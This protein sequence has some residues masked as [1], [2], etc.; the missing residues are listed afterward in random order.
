MMSWCSVKK[1]D[2]Y[3]PDLFARHAFRSYDTGRFG[4]FATSHQSHPSHMHELDTIGGQARRKERCLQGI[5]PQKSFD[6]THAE[7]RVFGRWEPR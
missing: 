5:L 6:P 4:L 1:F 3:E 7:C 2:G